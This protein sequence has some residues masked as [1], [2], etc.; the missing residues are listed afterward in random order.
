MRD[1]EHGCA[2]M[3]VKKL[4]EIT[5]AFGLTLETLY[6]KEVLEIVYL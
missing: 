1:I 3:A 4:L 2:S 5:V 6:L